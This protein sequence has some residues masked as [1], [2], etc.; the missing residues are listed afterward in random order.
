MKDNRGEILDSPNQS[1]RRSEDQPLSLIC[2]I[3]PPDEP[4]I[5]SI[6]WQFSKDGHTYT[7]IRDR[8]D[9]HADARGNELI[10]SSV[11][12]YDRGY[13]RCT[14]NDISFEILLRVKGRYFFRKKII[15][16]IFWFILDRLAALWPFI[17]IISV[18][19][20]LV[21]IILIFEKRQ[22]LNKKSITSDD[23]EQDQASDL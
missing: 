18:V 17:G 1:I 9:T 15:N 7:D 21:I 8:G 20:V 23:D 2:L 14:L 3:D 13:Y 19:L 4:S 10:I 5:R 11:K 16:F 6:R 12:K 22:K